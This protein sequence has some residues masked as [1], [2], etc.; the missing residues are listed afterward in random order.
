MNLTLFLSPKVRAKN[1]FS[2]SDWSNASFPLD[3]G[4]VLARKDALRG[5]FGA[6][7]GSS[8]AALVVSCL[9]F[10]IVLLILLRKPWD[11]KSSQDKKNGE[12]N[13]DL[14]MI[15][16]PELPSME[17][18]P[19]Y[20]LQGM[21]NASVGGDVDSIPKIKRDQITLTNFIGKGAFGQVYEGV[22]KSL[23]QTTPQNGE[24]QSTNDA[25]KEESGFPRRVAIK[26]LGKDANEEDR[27]K[28][29]QEALIMAR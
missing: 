1:D 21:S 29:L 5:G 28:F 25:A 17:V 15:A 23:A 22:A 14:E 24:E 13:A 20:D 27:T 6:V 8:V 11:A 3:I 12:K 10:V 26:V 9:V 4:Q 2:W 16:F 18:N 19:T 7:A